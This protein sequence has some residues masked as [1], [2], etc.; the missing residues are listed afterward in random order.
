M[1]KV[2]QQLSKVVKWDVVFALVSRFASFLSIWLLLIRGSFGFC[3]HHSLAEIVL[4]Q[5]TFWKKLNLWNSLESF[6]L[7]VCVLIW[8]VYSYLFGRAQWLTPVIPALWEA[9]MGRS[10]E[11]RS[12][13]PAWPTWWN[14]IISTKNTKKISWV[15]WQA[16]VVPATQEAEAGEW[17]EPGRR[18][19]QWA[20]IVPLH[21]SLGNR[22]RL[23]L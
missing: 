8:F 7:P 9:E 10:L 22:A 23:C 14:P 5:D 13:R 1:P 6:S 2:L 20:E 12:S 21:S 18:S 15:W 11:V 16:L 4:L 17:H 3:C 19:L